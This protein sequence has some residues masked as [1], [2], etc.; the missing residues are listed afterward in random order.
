LIISL[1]ATHKLLA[2]YYASF[3]VSDGGLMG[4]GP[5]I[6]ST[7]TGLPPATWT[8]SSGARSRPICRCCRADEVRA[9]INLKAA[10]AL[11][12]HIPA[13]VL[14]RADEVLE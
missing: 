10:N 5:L 2:V 14:A 11:G 6:S 12:L 3:L 7:S 8:A 4:Y 13:T 1:A 9:G